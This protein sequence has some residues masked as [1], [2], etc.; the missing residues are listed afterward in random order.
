[1]SRDVPSL[2]REE[3]WVG[4][5]VNMPEVMEGGEASSM[6]KSVEVSDGEGN[7]QNPEKQ[8]DGDL[9]GISADPEAD[10][11]VEQQDDTGEKLSEP[12]DPAIQVL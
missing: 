10:P 9:S 4:V 2:I 5:D 11:S 1:M 3:S 12:E 8:E 6:P 7:D